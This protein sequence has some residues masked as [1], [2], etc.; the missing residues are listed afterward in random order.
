MPFLYVLAIV[1]HVAFS[2]AWFGLSLSLPGLSRSII[3]AD[4][5][6]A[7]AL[8]VGGAKTVRQMDFFALMMYAFAFLTIIVGPG[9]EGIGWPFHIAL[10]LGLLLILV[11]AFLI[12]RNWSALQ[13]AVEGGDTGAARRKV[14][15]SL[16]LGH[17]IW[18]MLLVLM[19]LPRLLAV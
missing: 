8:A 2:A 10:S 6:V 12:R 7:E 15:M 4:R 18:S 1:L 16:R 11:Q 14:A 3:S 17:L 9:F 19:F 13:K 5:S